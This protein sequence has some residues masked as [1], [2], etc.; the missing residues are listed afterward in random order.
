MEAW[1]ATCE[2]AGKRGGICRSC[3]AGYGGMWQLG[4]SCIMDGCGWHDDDN[5]TAR[6]APRGGLLVFVFCLGCTARRSKVLW[7]GWLGLSRFLFPHC[8]YHR[9]AYSCYIA[10][11]GLIVTPFGLSGERGGHSVYVDN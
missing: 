5:G 4:I 9:P 2:R 10:S 7:T 3:L 1:W 11:V 6:E 8:F